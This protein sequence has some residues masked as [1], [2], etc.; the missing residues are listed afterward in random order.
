MTHRPWARSSTSSNRSATSSGIRI[1]ATG[2]PTDHP[3][4]KGREAV[5]AGERTIVGL[6][7]DIVAVLGERGHQQLREMLAALLATG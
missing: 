4:D 7:Q 3:D 2:A 5:A 1:H 6:E